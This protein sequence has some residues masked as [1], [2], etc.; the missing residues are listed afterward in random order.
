MQ[1]LADYFSSLEN[2]VNKWSH[3]FISYR[4]A[5]DRELARQLHDQLSAVVLE[6]TGGQRIRVYLDQTRLED[7]QRWDSGFME[8]LSKS[9]VFVPIVSVGALQPMMG[10]SEAEDW[11]DNVLLEWTA[12]L[13]LA[14]RGTV[15]A[16]LPLL[17]GEKDDF[18]VEAESAFGGLSSLPAHSSVATMEKVVTHLHETTADASLTGLRRML[19][20]SEAEVDAEQ[21]QE[22]QGVEVLATIRSVVSSVLKYQGVKVTR[23]RDAVSH[24]HGAHGSVD[25]EDLTACVERVRSTVSSCL[26]RVGMQEQ[27]HQGQQMALPD[28]AAGG[29]GGGGGSSGMYLQVAD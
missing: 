14:Q 6:E 15:K 2:M 19:D 17:L 29:S 1:L 24:A 3:V 8:G 9:W 13:E 16:V 25:T 22:Q 7:G 27:R 12:A 20:I 5:S 10:M 23:N 21:G 18:F 28:D 4:V 11:C 26:K